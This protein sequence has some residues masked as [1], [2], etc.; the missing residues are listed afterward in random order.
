[1]VWL[2]MASAGVGGRGGQIQVT[3]CI[4]MASRHAWPCCGASLANV[5]EHAF[6]VSR[7]LASLL[8]K[9]TVIL[10]FRA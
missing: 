2:G 10:E 9:P 1:M 4:Y 6:L 8:K 3:V 7:F 5:P